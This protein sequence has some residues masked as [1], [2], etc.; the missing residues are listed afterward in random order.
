MLISRDTPI[1]S[2]VQGT[3]K[4]IENNATNQPRLSLNFN[5][6]D[7]CLARLNVKT[8]TLSIMCKLLVKTTSVSE[9]QRV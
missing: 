1:L 3:D 2:A 6:C 7:L 5:G 4:D 9:L 8:S